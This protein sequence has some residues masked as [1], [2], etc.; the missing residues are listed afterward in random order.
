MRYH[1]KKESS[2]EARVALIISNKEIIG[3]AER[4]RQTHGGLNNYKETAG[5]T[6]E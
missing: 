3:D 5:D 4:Q 2:N 1:G 6:H